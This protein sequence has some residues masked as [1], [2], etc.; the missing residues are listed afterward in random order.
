MVEVMFQ[1]AVALLYLLVISLGCKL[2]EVIDQLNAIEAEQK[3]E[4]V[5]FTYDPV[6]KILVKLS[7]EGE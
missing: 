3:A 5:T 1:L 2:D 6:N 4:K 7:G